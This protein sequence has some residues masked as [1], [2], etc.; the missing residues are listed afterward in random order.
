MGTKGIRRARRRTG[1]ITTDTLWGRRPNVDEMGCV[2]SNTYDP[3][4]A[5]REIGGTGW[6]GTAERVSSIEHGGAPH[7]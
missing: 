2:Q 1:R 7:R 5:Y 3:V 6:V 4:M